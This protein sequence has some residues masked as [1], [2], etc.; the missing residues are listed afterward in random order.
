[1]WFGA[2]VPAAVSAWG[3]RKRALDVRACRRCLLRTKGSAGE[4][5]RPAGTPACIAAVAQ[6]V[7]RNLAK[8]E[9]ESSGLFCRSKAMA[10]LMPGTFSLGTVC[11]MGESDHLV[12]LRA[13]LLMVGMRTKRG[14]RFG[15][16]MDRSTSGEVTILSRWPGWVRIPHGLPRN[17]AGLAQWLSESLPSLRGRFDSGNPLHFLPL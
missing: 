11:T 2:G 14:H 1:M 13:A 17:N 6:L 12:T 4:A 5:T 8:V 3:S 7:E 10:S 9:V 15:M 16:S